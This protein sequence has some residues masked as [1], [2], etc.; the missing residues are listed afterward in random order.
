MRVFQCA[1]AQEALYA[2]RKEKLFTFLIDFESYPPFCLCYS[3]ARQKTKLIFSHQKSRRHFDA[4]LTKRVR[5]LRTQLDQHRLREEF[6]CRGAMQIN[7]FHTFTHTHTTQ[8]QTHT[9][10]ITNHAA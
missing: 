5:D 1:S 3:L 4:G 2:H 8:T 9:H 6:G 10:T 7:N